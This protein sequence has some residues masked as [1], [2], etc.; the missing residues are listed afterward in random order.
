[1]GKLELVNDSALLQPQRL[2][3]P[4]SW[5]GH[6]PFSM[7]LIAR[8]KPDLLVE[9]G[10]HT[11]NSYFSFCQSV[12]ANGLSTRCYAVDTWQG[13]EQAGY[14]GDEVYGDIRRYNEQNYVDFSRLLRMTF[15]QAIDQFSDGSIDLLHIDGLH[16]YEAVLHDFE[17]WKPK[18]SVRAVVLF[19]DIVVRD[20]DFGV[21]K[22]WEELQ[23]Q[24]PHFQF[25][26]SNGL[27]VLFVGKEQPETN[28]ALL[29]ELKKLQKRERFSHFFEQ[30]GKAPV[31]ELEV[32]SLQRSIAEYNHLV[33][34]LQGTVQELQ[35]TVQKNN[36][37]I[38]ILDR[39]VAEKKILQQRVRTLTVERDSLLASTSWRLTA[40]VRRCV[41]AIRRFRFFLREQLLSVYHRL[42]LTLNQRVAI[43]AWYYRSKILHSFRRQRSNPTTSPFS[44][45]TTAAMTTAPS[46]I[47]VIERTVPRPNQDAGSVMIANFIQVL[48]QMGTAVTFIP[49]DLAY[50]P[51]YTPE[52]QNLGVECL[53]RPD[54]G[55][56]EAHLALAGERYDFILVCRPDDAEALLPLFKSYSPQACLLYETHDLHFVREQRQAEMEDDSELLQHA[57]WRRKQE[58]HIAASVDCTLVVSEVERQLL[59]QENP[60]LVVEVIPVIG[61][62][63]GCQGDYS[64]RQDLIFIGGYQHRPNVD[65]VIYFVEEIFPQIVAQIPGIKFLVVGSHPPAEISALASANVI[66]HGFVPDIT[67]LM[68]NVRISVNPLRF[69]AGV[70]GKMVTSMSYGVPCVGTRIAVEGMD[71]V[72]G[73]HALVADEAQAFAAEVVRLYTDQQLWNTL[74]REGLEFVSQ[75]FSLSV[76]TAAF[77]RIFAQWPMLNGGEKLS[78]EQVVSSAAYCKRQT[79]DELNRRQQVEAAYISATEP[80]IT[81]GFC[82][83]CGCEVDFHTDFSFGFNQLDGSMV[84]NWRERMVC[85]R[86][87]LNNRMR[88]SIH[89]F[90]LLC[91]PTPESCFYLTEQTTPL[92]SWFKNNY[93]HVTGSEFLGDAIA[94]GALDSAGIRNENLAELTF[95]A[96]QFDAILSFDVFEHI[97]D[98][99]QAFR[100]CLRCLKPGGSLFFSVPFALQSKSHI[101]RAEIDASGEIHHLLPPEYHGDPL[102]S[103]GCLC[104]YHFGWELL[105]Q[106]RSLGFRDASAYLYWSDHFGYLGGEQLVFRAV[107]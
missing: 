47:L 18:L 51:E 89:L 64:Q 105:D 38:A 106:L 93:T 77:K 63:F 41:S 44:S 60:E 99:L 5:A 75:H 14:Y 66:I 100:S 31:L 43:R 3:Q 21:W 48:R 8:L 2:I 95:A 79:D 58:L 22:L 73:K 65:A 19:H 35:G 23:S 67:T 17:S 13:D 45:L 76:A 84:P 102:S 74:S 68:N 40:P 71:I 29:A 90:H 83:V 46:H 9:L 101:V 30:L 37:K 78:L 104:Y 36:Q 4:P 28:H 7:W 87:R 69:G 98:Y 57:K 10:T 50:D 61:E 55:S 16:T 20:R 26:H 92:F 94:L 27:G 33:Q 103:E 62:T 96:E 88:A 15:D 72:P 81:R 80:I 70:K 1:M 86:C 6:I 56:I 54:I 52:L 24:Y 82:F 97:P 59:L 49:C 85:P 107:K 91:A 11:G 53:H 34:E 39:Q 25:E 32:G 42:P 12:Q